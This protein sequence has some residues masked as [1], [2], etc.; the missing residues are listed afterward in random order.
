MQSG[1]DPYLALVSEELKSDELGWFVCL[2]CGF[3]YRSPVLDSQELEKLY[4]NYE[5]TIFENE[6]PDDY[7]ER[8][9]TLS[10]SESENH[11]KVLWLADRLT[12]FFGDENLKQ[13]CTLDVGCGG[14]TLL[15]SL[16]Q[17]IPGLRVHGVELNPEYAALAKR[18]L[19]SQILCCEYEPSLF[20]HLFDLVINTKVLEHVPDPERF[21]SYF[22]A[23]LKDGGLC[24][25]EV[26]DISDLTNL[27]S[28]HSRFYIPH[29]HYF[30]K[31]SLE[32]VL[33]RNGFSVLTHRVISSRNRRSY[34]QVL[35]QKTDE[36][37]SVREMPFDDPDSII[38]MVSA[39]H[40]ESDGI[41]V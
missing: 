22:H 8:I 18:R 5:R 25:V 36:S 13:L 40:A 7:F 37:N 11:Q 23:D 2:D 19:S 9:T 4:R 27:P 6:S 10:A 14:G 20:E 38:E 24:F 29:I 26:P 1:Q 31:N 30:S 3:V 41:R 17:A 33:R 35:A 16:I 28:S 12:E 21:V 39:N 34:L 32:E 15:W